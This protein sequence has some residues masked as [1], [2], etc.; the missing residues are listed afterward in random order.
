MEGQYNN[1][2]Y[3]PNA[4]PYPNPN[5]NPYPNPNANPYPN[6]N[7]NPYPN[8]NAPA[9][10]VKAPK[11]KKKLKIIAIVA[12]VVAVIAAVLFMPSEFER[13]KD[14]AVDIAGQV[15]S[16]GDNNFTIDTYPYEDTKMSASMI[17]A[18]APETQDDALDAIQY[19]NEAFGFSSSVYTKML[20]TSAAMGR[21]S[22]S[23]EK[24]I[25]SWTYHP[26]EGLEVTYTKK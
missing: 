23:N 25:V 10:E 11:K 9:P 2:V 21:Q 5:V 16:R 13:V 8:P 20:K 4:N 22:E 18:L 26:D 19:V 1:G 14:K 17:A 12:V 6:P 15:S 24:Y 7:A 3:N